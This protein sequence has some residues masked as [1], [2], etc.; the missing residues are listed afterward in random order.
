MIVQDAASAMEAVRAIE[1]AGS[2]DPVDI[3]L[4]GTTLPD[5]SALDCALLLRQKAPGRP[6]AMAIVCPMRQQESLQAGID[7]C[8]HASIGIVARPLT[9]HAFVDGS[10]RLIDPRHA[11]A[12][13]PAAHGERLAANRAAVRGARVLLVDD[14]A[15]NQELTQELLGAAGVSVRLASNGREALAI[16]ARERFDGVLMDCQMPVMDGYEATRALRCLPHLARLPVIAMTANAMVDDIRRALEAGMNDHVAKPV[17]IEP[18]FA[19]LARWL[20][21]SAPWP[22]PQGEAPLAA[23]AR[24]EL[25]GV[26]VDRVV[27][28]LGGD[29]ALYRRMLAMFRDAERDFP[30]RLQAADSAGD[31]TAAID[32]V[33]GLCGSAG[34]LGMRDLFARAG[35]LEGVLRDAPR[36]ARLDAVAGDE[37]REVRDAL[38]RVFLELD[39]EMAVGDA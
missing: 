30:Q 37:L 11:L 22:P 19:T 21:P 8:G 6:P 31:R 13:P 39:R 33:H 1:A 24:P 18:F 17:A 36:D 23:R 26:D 20:K 28:N 27:D 2:R 9:F 5:M 25:A 3:V 15:I 7:R 34:S 4:V 16:L 32:I 38:A 14:N 10:A 12:A 35:R 29:V